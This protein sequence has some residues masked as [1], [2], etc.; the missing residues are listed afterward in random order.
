MNHEVR[1]L[2]DTLNCFTKGGYMYENEKKLLKLNV[3]QLRDAEVF[4]P[5]DLNALEERP[6]AAEPL[7]SK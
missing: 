2:I 6:F 1:V 4:L 3:Q 5:E 7:T